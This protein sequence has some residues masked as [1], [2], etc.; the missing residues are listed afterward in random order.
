M[1]VALSGDNEIVGFVEITARKFGLGDGLEPTSDSS[2]SSSSS[3]SSPFA[4]INNRNRPVVSNLVVKKSFRRFGVARSL[5]VSCETLVNNNSAWR[6]YSEIVLQVE[7]ENLIARRFYEASGYEV[8]FRDPS[9]R[10]YDADGLFLRN[11]RTTKL[12]L[13]KKLRSSIFTR[14][15]QP[16]FLS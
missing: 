4:G 13:R 9:C 2:S 7:D 10:R 15:T 11:V 8:L 6:A 5:M 14:L 3:P 16:W 12:C 1:Y